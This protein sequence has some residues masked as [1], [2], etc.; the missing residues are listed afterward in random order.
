MYR[1]P[2]NFIVRVLQQS[3]GLL[4]SMLTELHVF[5]FSVVQ[6]YTEP[7]LIVVM[8]CTISWTHTSVVHCTT[9]NHNKL[10]SIYY[11]GLCLQR[12]TGLRERK[13]QLFRKSL[14]CKSVS[15][16]KPKSQDGFDSQ[17]KTIEE[18]IRHVSAMTI[19][20]LV[21]FTIVWVWIP[22]RNV[23]TKWTK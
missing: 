6:D 11:T 22:F 17:K 7:N 1:T 19:S 5:W 13:P 21:F 23:L 9:L 4:Y 12:S 10:S 15:I 3:T 2:L 8:K 14:W 20:I 16:C 18:L